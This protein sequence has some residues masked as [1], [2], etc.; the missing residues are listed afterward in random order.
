MRSIS[1]FEIQESGNSELESL[2]AM[3]REVNTRGILCGGP[4][5]RN[6]G[7]VAGWDTISLCALPNSVNVLNAPVLC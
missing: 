1:G 2:W 5:A 6:A 7:T 3:P 4:K